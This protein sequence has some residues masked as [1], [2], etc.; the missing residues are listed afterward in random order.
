[1]ALYVSEESGGNFT[2]YIDFSGTEK[3]WKIANPNAEMD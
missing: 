3:V 2:P 1:M